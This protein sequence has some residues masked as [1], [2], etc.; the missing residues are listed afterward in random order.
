[1]I[2]ACKCLAYSMPVFNF[3]QVAEVYDTY[4]DT[5]LGRQVDHVE[6]QLVWKY[7][8]RMNL[9][10]PILEIGCGTGH[11]TRF[12]RKK[13]LKLTAIDL[14]AKMLE[15]AREKNP[16][17]VHFER[18][19]VE[20]M[21]FGDY[22]FVNIISIATLE[23]VDN[24]EKA[25][26]EIDRV[27]K[28]GGILIIGCLNALSEMGRYKNENEMFRTAHFFKPDE[29]KTHLS[30]FDSPEIEGCAII[31]DHQ[32]L[33]YPDI[34]QVEPSVRLIRGAFLTGFVKKTIS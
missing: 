11:W 3:D 14:S 31:E 33:D 18:M 34:D 5:Q 30:I 15:K 10:Q 20:N 21:K 32:V 23:F 29:L 6:K 22:A 28:P 16:Q 26:Q 12:F 19:N 27:L 9:G 13:G 7:M 24:R 2:S 17:N 4:Y 1:M 8:I 25:F